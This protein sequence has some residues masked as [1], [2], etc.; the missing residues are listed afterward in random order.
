[1]NDVS[2]FGSLGAG[3]GHARYYGK[4]R[5]R[6][7][8]NR[9]PRSRGRLR[10]LTPAVL[11]ETEVWALPCTPYAG[12]G[13]GWFAMPPVG[14]AV[15]VEFEA[16]DLDHPIW[17]GC[18]WT[19]DQSPP[20]G[21]ADPNVKVLKTDKATVRIDDTRGE[22]EIETEG[23]SKLKLTGVDGTLEATTV[24]VESASGKAS[25]SAAGVDM[26][27]GAFTVI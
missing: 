25:F 14:A 11:F 10:V 9:D 18:F 26:N 19:D 4:Y 21:G 20:E 22:I 1:M 23:G 5:G 3:V 7:T 2:P 27:D 6:V 17:S 13:V 24:K 15:W 12:D 16:G 8:D